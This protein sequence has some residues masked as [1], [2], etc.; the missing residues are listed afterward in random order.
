[1]RLA[2][3]M[4]SWWYCDMLEV[5]KVE[6]VRCGCVGVIAAIRGWLVVGSCVAG[7]SRPAASARRVPGLWRMQLLTV[8]CRRVNVVVG[9]GTDVKKIDWLANRFRSGCVAVDGSIQI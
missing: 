5:M 8:R 9:G 1:M 4:A 6:A 7:N 3:G 2:N